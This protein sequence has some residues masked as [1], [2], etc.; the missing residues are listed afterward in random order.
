MTRRPREPE[1]P[2]EAP[3]REQLEAAHQ[4]RD[5]P[6]GLHEDNVRRNVGNL[7]DS[8]GIECTFSYP[9]P[10]GPADLYLQRRRTI[11]ETKARGL[12]GTP[13]APQARDNPET[14]LQQLERYLL[15]ELRNEKG[16]FAFEEHGDRPWV[17]IL[18]DGF[19]WHAWLYDHDREARAQHLLDGFVPNSAEELIHRVAPLISGDP[20]GK[21]WI[22]VDPRPLFEP[23]HDELQA[24]Y[25]ELGGANLAETRT[26]RDLWLDMLRTASMEPENE[27]ARDRL[28]VTHSFL[29]ALAR[30]VVQTLADPAGDP[31]P[32]NVLGDGF[33]AW[34]LA[35]NRGRNW[36]ASL[37]DRIHGYEWRRRR[38][39]VLRP[40]YERFVG[41]RDRKVFGEYYTPDWLAGLIVE[42]LL[43]DAW[44]ARAIAAAIAD[45]RNQGRLAGIGFLDPA[46]GSGTILYHA[47]QRLLEAPALD[48]HTASSRAAVVARLVNG[49]D[50]HPVAA[51]ISRAT[52]L[53]ALP[54]EPPGGKAG[55]RIYEGDSLLVNADDDTSLFRPQNGEIRIATPQGRELLLPRSFVDLPSFADDLRRL[56]EEATR[57]R[58]LS[59]DIRNSVPEEDR[60][61]VEACHTAFIEIV[62]EEGNSVWT[63]YIA[64]TTGPVRLSDQKVD[65]IVANPPWVS[66]TDIQAEVR[67]RALEQFADT[68]LDL[69]TGGRNAPHFDIAQLFIKRAR[70]L[71]LADPDHDPAAWIVKKSA[72]RA[73]GWGKFREWH[74]PILAQSLDLEAVQPFGG[75]DARRCCVLFERRPSASLVPGS[76]SRAIR[77]YCPDGRPDPD[78]ALDQARD[79]VIFENTPAPLPRQAS[80]YVDDRHRTPFRQ[81]ASVSPRVLVAVSEIAD[82]P[83]HDEK[84]VTTVPSRQDPW[85]QLEPQTGV[86]PGHW[87][88]DLLTSN[89]VFA[90]AIPSELLRAIIPT[91]TDGRLEEAPENLSP[92]WRLLDAAY[93]ELRG[94]GRNT[95]E[96]LIAQLDHNGKLSA[97][98]TRAGTRRTL[99][100]YPKSG[101]IMRGARSRAGPITVDDTLYYCNTASVGEAA[102]LTSVLNAPSLARAFLESRT[103][104]RDFHQ[105][106][107]RAIPIPRYDATDPVH[108]DLARLCDRAE[109][110]ASDWLAQQ[111][112]SYGQIAASAR[113]RAL[114]AQRGIFA[115]IDRAAA[116][117]LPNHAQPQ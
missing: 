45:E 116:T 23:A 3:T 101:D 100:L 6:P 42:E 21:P 27:V 24:I 85:A 86:V 34:I 104:G 75:G 49:I 95:P 72:L 33:V 103:S 107:W 60:P 99:V 83:R 56:V 87:V 17:G 79:L 59:A 102:F 35:T 41:E 64:N 37:M 114:L 18:T 11:I 110:V 12:A 9:T 22:P 46:C 44:C 113:I 1:R 29:V 57:G 39:D 7:L 73:G 40:L 5:A 61:A 94:R 15:S 71:Y 97:Q 20:I 13:H 31:D 96:T 70:Q 19:V 106:P 105:N 55:I 58:P 84:R 48:G 77:A 36:A 74:E 54:A 90:F 92:F 81:G 10:G 38:G 112:R 78:T 67:K 50:V 115:A 89:Q 91:D 69:W 93:D 8:F 28:F 2:R 76:C 4:L 30:G 43:D 16:M 68:D 117:I 63:W 108:R 47:A 32:S 14:P 111:N 25:A 52:L 82:G 65:R 88:R 66:M 80:A 51:E 109:R 62:A 98:L 53:R 26:K